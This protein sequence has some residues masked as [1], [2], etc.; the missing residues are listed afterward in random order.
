MTRRYLDQFLFARGGIMKESRRKRHGFTLIE[1]LVVI[2]IIAVLVSLLLPAVQQAREAARRSQCRNNLK[3]LALAC[4]NYES[5]F[6]CIPGGSYSG[7]TFN[8]PHWSTYPEN[9]SV[10]VRVLPYIDQQNVYNQVNF[11]G[12]SSDASNLAICGVS[13]PTLI[14]PT[15]TNNEPVA[16]PAARSSSAG[17]SPGWSFNEIPALFPAA[18]TGYSQ[19]FT[20]Y[21]G[22][23]GT[24]TFG[25]SK[26]M[27]QK[28]LSK[29]NG[30]IYNDS[31]VK[32]RDIT[33]GASNTFLLAEHSK[34][35][36][37]ILDPAFAIS[38]GSWQSGRWYD[39]LFSTLYPLNLGYGNNTAIANSGY[40][41]P[42]TAGSLHPGGAHFA[43]CDGSVRFINNTINSW[44]F[45]AN[46]ADS[47]GDS[48]PD[49]SVF[50]T[51]SATA[52][53]TKSGS[54]LDTTGSILGVYQKL[55]TRNGGE[56]VSGDEY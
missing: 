56:I 18:V 45:A 17:V 50:T 48:M 4:L 28:V 43:F 11:N 16:F 52:P 3:Q 12:C 49:G 19:A 15:D 26:L 42:T 46:N 51:V 37:F 38:D 39:T 10:W 31:A 20:S 32:I 53:Y 35:Q 30:V 1:L 29:F 27:D 22:N 5:A 23:S 40:Y 9:F 34:D 13:I 36:L 7:T 21:A 33:D 2:A 41:D 6:G 47:F 25:Y 14:C 24:F 44:S 8:P 55:S 54:Y